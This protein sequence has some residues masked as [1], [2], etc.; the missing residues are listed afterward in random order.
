MTRR[1]QTTSQRG[2]HRSIPAPEK[3]RL[4]IALGSG[5]A[6]GWAHIGV[7]RALHE[8]GIEPAIIAGTS[9]GALVGGAYV[10]GQL[11]ALESWARSVGKLD[12]FRLMDLAPGRGGVI[13][14]TKIFEAFERVAA[15]VN[16]ED[17]PL[18]FT[19][20]ATDFE[21]GREIWLNKG[22]LHDAVRAS[23]S[24]PGLLPPV[25]YGD[26]W[27]VD[28]GLVNP[29]PV[30]VC[31]ALGADLVIAVNLSGVLTDRNTHLTT[32]FSIFGDDPSALEDTLE[33]L[34]TALRARLEGPARF[35]F[36]ARGRGRT[37][38]PGFFDVM[39]GAINIMQDRVTR[40][41]IAGDPADLLIEPRLE[42][43]R[44]LDFDHAA[45]A[46]AEGHAAA[47]RMRPA[48]ERLVGIQG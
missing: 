15:D 10:S 43:I 47:E 17:L 33:K 28:G 27:L 16:I 39:A 42:A 8:M 21:S 48:L 11:D 38:A 22:S 29:V 24:L 37:K 4:G 19:A 14:G 1:A 32:P 2:A 46:I 31:R 36:T 34:P 9:A 20:V 26:S 44:L 12:I 5:S 45:E 41:R 7:L 6:R 13:G 40:S 35:L 3:P 25:Q 30:S 23:V 18:P